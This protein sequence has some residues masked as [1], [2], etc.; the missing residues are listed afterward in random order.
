M[1]NSRRP[2]KCIAIF[3]L[4]L[5][6]VMPRGICFDGT[7]SYYN[8]TWKTLPFYTAF[9][10]RLNSPTSFTSRAICR[11]MGTIVLDKRDCRS[12]MIVNGDDVTII[13]DTKTN[14]IKQ[15]VVVPMKNYTA[16]VVINGNDYTIIGEDRQI[17]RIDPFG[18]W[19]IE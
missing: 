6:T 2:Y 3:G 1:M 18:M 15:S 12:I 7:H 11:R 5:L 13:G 8:A 9:T 14:N 10:N 16:V 4:A 17:S 19:V